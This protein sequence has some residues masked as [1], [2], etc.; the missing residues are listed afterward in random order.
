MEMVNK[1][2]NVRERDTLRLNLTHGVRCRQGRISGVGQ[3]LPKGGFCEQVHA[4]RSP[5]T[6]GKDARATF[7]SI[8][9][10]AS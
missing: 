5:K 7:T 6:S 9:S 3:C 8:T 10:S 2:R 4:E 1:C